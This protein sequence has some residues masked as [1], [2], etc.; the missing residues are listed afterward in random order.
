MARDG[1]NSSVN[2]SK[3]SH[4]EQHSK[5]TE[6]T[7]KR[8]AESYTV[9]LYI[10]LKN[11]GL[12]PVIRIKPRIRFRRSNYDNFSSSAP[13][14]FGL[15]DTVDFA[16]LK[17]SITSEDVDLELL[18]QFFGDAPTMHDLDNYPALQFV[19]QRD[20]FLRQ[21]PFKTKTKIIGMGPEMQGIPIG[22]FLDALNHSKQTEKIF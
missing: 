6:L 1:S 17:Q 8:Y 10:L 14:R 21:P 9:T 22:K 18:E 12:I 16:E 11:Y 19:S 3:L 4:R 15:D 13:L 2:C 7:L 5:K 20:L